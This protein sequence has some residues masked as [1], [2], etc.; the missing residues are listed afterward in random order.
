MHARCR[1][2]RLRFPPLA[3]QARV[4]GTVHFQAR[5]GLGGQGA[6]WLAGLEGRWGNR[7]SGTSIPPSRTPLGP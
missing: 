7:R 1:C 3:E 2:C 5:R 4:P 6:L